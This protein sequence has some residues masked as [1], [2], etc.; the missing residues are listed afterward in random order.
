MLILSAPVQGH[1]DA[2]YRHW[3][4]EI[5]SP[6]T[7]YFTPFIRWEKDGPR[8]RDVKDMTSGLNDNLNLVPQVIFRD[9]Q[10]LTSLL[11]L[12]HENDRNRVDIN[13]GCPFPLQNSAGRGAAMIGNTEVL[14]KLPE[15]LSNYPDI[16]F[17]MKMRLGY[18]DKE[19]WRKALPIINS[20]D[21][22]YVTMHPRIARQQY[23]GT[24][25][26]EQFEAFLKESR[27]PVIYNGDLNTPE[28]ISTI[29]ERF[30]EMAGVMTGRGMLARPSL[31]TEF[32]E[33]NEWD[34]DK[35]IEGMMRFHDALFSHYEDVLCGDSQILSKIKPFW[36]YA[37]QEIGRKAWK[38]IK[39]AS[40]LA[41]YNSAIA[42]I[43]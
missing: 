35:R 30:P 25:D 17:S 37:E 22:C 31:I 1:T 7:T 39:K 36:E 6:E 27:N 23:G 24:P 10:E 41:K 20:L 28:D 42:N 29:T 2:P 26:L 5:Y 40:T 15:I 8:I 32:Q 33:G 14:S 12:M 18:D 16:V 11:S 43:G 13:I 38:M 34:R 21:L 19:E 9:A 3:H 4:H